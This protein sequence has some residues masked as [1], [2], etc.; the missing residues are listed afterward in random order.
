LTQG[1]AQIMLRHHDILLA[2]A[3]HI[4]QDRAWLYERLVGTVDVRAFVSE[5]NFLL[6][7]VDRATDVFQGIRQRGVLIK[8][9]NGGHP[10]LS[11]CLRV[12]VGT[13]VENEQFMAALQSSIHQF[14]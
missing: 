1:V 11:D 8:N 13:E 12:T 6:F 2:Q 9:L 5:A 10:M 4:K 7:R 3:A 14:A